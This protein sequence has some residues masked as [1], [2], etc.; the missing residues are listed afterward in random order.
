MTENEKILTDFREG[1]LDT[2]YNKVYP[3]LLTYASRVLGTDYA[4]LAEDCVQDAILQGYQ[5]RHTFR[6]QFLFKAFL[7]T[8]IRNKAISI[9]RKSQAQE[10]YI[11]E[12]KDNETDFIN[13]IIEQEVMTSLYS[14]ID[15]LPENYRKLF[16]LSFEQGLKNAEVA[17]ILNVSESTIVKHKAQLIE[18]LRQALRNDGCYD[19]VLFTYLFFHEC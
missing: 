9:L 13:G 7:Y 12:Q 18:L 3:G 16:E 6:S 19:L 4:F 10:N 1:K 14:A 11:S 2:L 8:C 15:T 5:Q 17:A